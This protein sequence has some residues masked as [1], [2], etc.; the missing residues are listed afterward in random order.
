M[1]AFVSREGP[2]PPAIRVIPCPSPPPRPQP[3]ALTAP[4]LLANHR[5]QPSPFAARDSQPS[6]LAASLNDLRADTS[7][8][9]PASTAR[10]RGKV[11][12]RADLVHTPYK[13]SPA[14]G[15]G[16]TPSIRTHPTTGSAPSSPVLPSKF[17]RPVLLRG[18]FSLRGELMHAFVSYRVAT[19][20][21]GAKRE[22]SLLTTYW[23]ESTYSS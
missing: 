20:G 12:L 8:H 17:S 6:P 3:A 13:T 14:S 21:K 7:I 5:P 9:A 10:F 19:E 1:D 18:N 16:R 4:A 23:S 22:S 2:S 15:V 11:S